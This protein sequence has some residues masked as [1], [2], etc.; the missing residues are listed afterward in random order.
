MHRVVQID[1]WLLVPVL[2]LVASGLVM[3]GSS[4]IAIAESHGVSSYYYLV[5]HMIYIVLGVMLASTFRVIPIA[6]LERISRPMMWLSALVLLLVFIPGLG[7]SVNGSARWIT[8]GF[9]NFQVVEAVKIMVIIY[10]A[11]YLVRKAD[12]VKI[13]FFDTLKPLILAAML[14]A[15]LLAQPDMGSAAVITATF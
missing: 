3:V 8:I 5:R 10:M 11:G 7:R 14:T 4:S 1:A 6:F 2:L 13:R 12:M 15:I 9:A